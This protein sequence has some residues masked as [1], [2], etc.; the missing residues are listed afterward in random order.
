MHWIVKCLSTL[1][2][3][4]APTRYVAC[5]NVRS[6]NTAKQTMA[7]MLRW[8]IWLPWGFLFTTKPQPWAALWE[9][10]YV[11]FFRTWTLDVCIQ[12]GASRMPPNSRVEEPN[13][14]ATGMIQIVRSHQIPN[15]SWVIFGHRCVDVVKMP[16]RNTSGLRWPRLWSDLTSDVCNQDR[17]HANQGL[18]RRSSGNHQAL[19]WIGAWVHAFGENA[20]GFDA[21]GFNGDKKGSHAAGWK[22]EDANF[23]NFNTTYTTIGHMRNPLLQTW[24]RAEPQCT[25]FHCNLD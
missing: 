8:R 21:N 12:S 19:T 2:L 5:H 18:S 17:D 1:G 3:S 25:Q 13:S 11:T 22:F 9:L 23:G 20:D 14:Y 24:K 16:R 15:R 4:E 6:W 7:E 10:F